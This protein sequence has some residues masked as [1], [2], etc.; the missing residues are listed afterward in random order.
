MNIPTNV[1]ANLTAAGSADLAG[2]ADQF[3]IAGIVNVKADVTGQTPVT[4]VTLSNVS[5]N[6]T[7]QKSASLNL[8]NLQTTAKTLSVANGTVSLKGETA[9]LTVVD[10]TN[11]GTIDA[12]GGTLTVTGTFDNTDGKIRCSRA[13]IIGKVA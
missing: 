5:V 4:S 3:N 13:Q 7:T 6:G 1:T 11:A 10:L 9:S 12:T 8:D 2:G